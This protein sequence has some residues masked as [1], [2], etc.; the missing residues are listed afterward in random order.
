MMARL[1][2]DG[3][4][5]MGGTMA[6]EADGDDDEGRRERICYRHP[7][8]GDGAVGGGRWAVGSGQWAL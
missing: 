1:V 4:T 7:K 2:G 5:E 6:G 8:G 3:R